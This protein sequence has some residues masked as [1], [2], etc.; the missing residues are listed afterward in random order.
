MFLSALN[1]KEDYK[2]ANKKP[3]LGYFNYF[4]FF[5][6]ADNLWSKIYLVEELHA[7]KNSILQK[8]FPTT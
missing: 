1:S 6:S 2:Q 3:I 8:L 5:N 7:D 4:F